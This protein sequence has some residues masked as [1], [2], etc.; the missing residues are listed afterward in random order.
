MISEVSSCI[1][2][3]DANAPLGEATPPFTG[4]HAPEQSN[5]QT[6]AFI[7]FS[8]LQ[9]VVRAAS[10]SCHLKHGSTPQQVALQRLRDDIPAAPLFCKILTTLAHTLIA[11]LQVSIRL[12]SMNPRNTKAIQWEILC[13]ALRCAP[14]TLPMPERLVCADDHCRIREAQVLNIQEQK[15]LGLS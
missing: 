14:V 9:C 10:T 5:E 7:A 8:T 2:C 12:V 11:F 4:G 1:A 3:V 13:E 15:R 6:V